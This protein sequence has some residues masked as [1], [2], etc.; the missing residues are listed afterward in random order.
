MTK[1]GVFM[2]DK[3]DLLFEGDD[4]IKI[5]GKKAPEPSPYEEKAKILEQLEEAEPPLQS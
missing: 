2:S 3:T 4:D 5:A 1:R